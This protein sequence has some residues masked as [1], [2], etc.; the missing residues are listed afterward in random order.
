MLR[1]WS[2]FA[3]RNGSLT[4]PLPP[5]NALADT[6]WP[7]AFTLGEITG[8]R[9]LNDPYGLS[10]E[11]YRAAADYLLY[12]CEDILAMLNTQCSMLN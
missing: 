3:I 5:A 12:A 9:D 11:K 10:L 2:A 6:V 4:V 8:G 7:K 1:N